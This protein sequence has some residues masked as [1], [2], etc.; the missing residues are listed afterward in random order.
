MHDRIAAELGIAPTSSRKATKPARIGTALA[1]AASAA[2]VPARA[3]EGTTELVSGGQAN[4]RSYQPSISADGRRVAFGPYASNLVP[5]DTN[6][7][8]DVFVRSR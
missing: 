8:S 5:G 4:G 7:R 3:A 6:G 1:L 2:A